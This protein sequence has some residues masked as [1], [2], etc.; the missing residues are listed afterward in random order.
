M[1]HTIFRKLGFFTPLTSNASA[2]T[3]QMRKTKKMIEEW[4]QPS[5]TW[6]KF[7]TADKLYGRIIYFNHDGPRTRD[8]HNILK[9]LFDELKGRVY[10]DDKVIFH[11]EGVRLE[12][13]YYSVWFELGLN[14][15]NEPDLAKVFQ[16]TACPIEVGVL[17]MVP[18][19]TVTVKWLR[20]GSEV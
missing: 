8:I 6:N 18:S 20:A 19:Q 12:M 16:E 4:F 15:S 11:F 14:L 3:P 9:P 5:I 17:P 7:S 10:E 1:N 2:T 13:E